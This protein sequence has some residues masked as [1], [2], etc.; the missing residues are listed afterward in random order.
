MTGPILGQL[1]YSVSVSVLPS[2][3]LYGLRPDKKLSLCRL[4]QFPRRFSGCLYWPRPDNPF[5]DRETIML[6][7]NLSVCFIRS[8]LVAQGNSVYSILFRRKL[9]DYGLL[10]YYLYFNFS[11]VTFI[12]HDF[13]F[14]FFLNLGFT[15]IFPNFLCSYFN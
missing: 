9:I 10:Y 11:W 8:L 2:G 6:R 14:L 13:S 1:V 12:I 4:L 15:L 7:S 5:I 3:L